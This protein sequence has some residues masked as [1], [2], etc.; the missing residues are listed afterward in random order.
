MGFSLKQ[1][2][3][4][5]SDKLSEYLAQ[6]YAYNIPPNIQNQIDNLTRTNGKLRLDRQ[7]LTTGQLCKILNS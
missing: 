7:E 6:F 3:T 4:I 2:A 1:I 5:P